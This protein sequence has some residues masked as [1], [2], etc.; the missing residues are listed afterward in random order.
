MIEEL[1]IATKCV[2]IVR[3]LLQVS[4]WD[5]Q[6]KLTIIRESTPEIRKGVALSV[7]RPN[8]SAG[9]LYKLIEVKEGESWLDGI[10]AAIAHVKAQAKEDSQWPPSWAVGSSK[11]YEFT[12]M[13]TEEGSK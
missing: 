9:L 1:E 3:G 13:T 5:Q 2:D 10:L 4:D 8:E 7:S 6:A 11:L 12:E